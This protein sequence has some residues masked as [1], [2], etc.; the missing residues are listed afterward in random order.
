[1]MSAITR[2]AEALHSMSLQLGG[3]SAEEADPANL[4][5]WAKYAV[6][7][8]TQ[9]LGQ[10]AAAHSVDSGKYGEFVRVLLGQTHEA[11]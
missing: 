8:Y 2:Y 10:A 6:E 5:S 9:E 1:M 11:A 3:P 4:A 7:A